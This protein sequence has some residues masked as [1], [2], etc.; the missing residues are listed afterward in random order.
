MEIQENAAKMG[1]STPPAAKPA[2]RQAINI[3]YPKNPHHPVFVI[4]MGSIMQAVKDNMTMIATFP[5]RRPATPKTSPAV[6]PL[7]PAKTIIERGVGFRAEL[8]A[9]TNTIGK[10]IAANIED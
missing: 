6:A 5:M 4:Q 3:R 8:Y 2:G 1:C 10:Q 9:I 7:S